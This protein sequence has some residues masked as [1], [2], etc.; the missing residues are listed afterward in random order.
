MGTTEQKSKK[1]VRMKQWTKREKKT[2]QDERERKDGSEKEL[3]QK[4]NR[5]DK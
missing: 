5:D 2:Y 4:A 3:K 1:K